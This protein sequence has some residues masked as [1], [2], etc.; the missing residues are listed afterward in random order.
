MTEEISKIIA[1]LTAIEEKVKAIGDS[2]PYCGPLIDAQ[3]HIMNAKEHLRMHARN[4][5]RRAAMHN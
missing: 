4:E 2:T 3:S 5:E 1:E